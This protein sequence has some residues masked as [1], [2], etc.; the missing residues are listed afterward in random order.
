MKNIPNHV[1]LWSQIKPLLDMPFGPCSLAFK[2]GLVKRE[3]HPLPS[4]LYKL[5]DAHR[6][7]SRCLDEFVLLARL[8]RAKQPLRGNCTYGDHAPWIKKRPIDI[9]F[10]LGWKVL[11]AIQALIGD[12]IS[13]E[14]T[15]Q[16]LPGFIQRIADLINQCERTLPQ[17]KG[18]IRHE[19][20]RWRNH[21]S[22]IAP[23]F[24][25]MLSIIE[26]AF[27]MAGEDSFA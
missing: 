17:I 8:L 16:F 20:D 3:Q 21:D 25:S 11:P 6:E 23:L 19:Y 22:L 18:P 15:N 13:A 4:G 12:G 24:E 26:T 1:I 9:S 5:R 7:M 10:E 27:H 14:E 2:E